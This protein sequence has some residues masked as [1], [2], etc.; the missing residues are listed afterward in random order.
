MENKKLQIRN[1]TAEFLTFTAE[2]GEKSIEVMYAEENVW[3]T[4]EMMAILYD[5]TKQNIS[6]HLINAYEDKEIDESATVKEFL[7]VQ[8]DYKYHMVLYIE[9]R[10]RIQ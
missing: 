8:N 1:S 9:N 2:T 3:S 6:L 10:G 4:Q 7:T 5:T